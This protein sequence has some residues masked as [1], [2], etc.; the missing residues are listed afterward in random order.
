VHLGFPWVNQQHLENLEVLVLLVHQCVLVL[1]KGF[2]LLLGLLGLLEV[3]MHLELLLQH[4]YHL[5]HLEHL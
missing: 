3:L 4:L 5:G 2:L 1:Q